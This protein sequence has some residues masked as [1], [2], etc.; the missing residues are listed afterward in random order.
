MTALLERLL[1]VPAVWLYVVVTALVFVED[2]LFV[3]FVVP[4]E[5]A[6]VL[7]GVAAEQGRVS[8]WL[9]GALVVAA[10]V[11][12]DSV[13]YEV[14]RHAGPRLLASRMA[15][16]HQEGIDRATDTLARKG[17]PA[18]LLARL[19]AFLRAVTPALA[20]VAGMRYRTFLTWNAVG[21]LLWGVGAVLIGYLAGAS[22]ESVASTVGT[23][24]AV[25][26]AAVV[27]VGLLVW[28]VRRHRSTPTAA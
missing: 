16:R 23:T 22:W 15:R 25:V 4:A 2:A 11:L 20:G 5:T 14:G 13:G 21:G 26:V 6:V 3:G 10:A 28:R 17:G 24:G 7:G 8:V 19:T 18:V 9:L 12:G 27:V 1:S